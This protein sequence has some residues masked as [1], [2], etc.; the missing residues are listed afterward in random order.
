MSNKK[1]AVILSGCGVYDGAEINEVVLTL[2]AL[3]SNDIQYQCFAPDIEQYHTVDHTTGDTEAIPRNVL[4]ESARIVRGEILPLTDCLIE[5]FA[6]VIVPGGFGV[7]KS[8]SN[9]AAAESEFHVEK[10]TLSTLRKFADKKKPAGY[11]CIAPVLIPTV[12][13][14]DAK[15][16][17]G[18]D[19]SVIEFIRRSGGMHQLAGY[20]E[21]VF[22]EEKK[23]V[24]T[25]AFMLAKNL[26]EAKIGIDKLVDKVVSLC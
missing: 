18:N 24:T 6:A 4:K 10:S 22:D 17:I 20:D 5:E 2:L 26:R 25:P 12:Y 1:V 14:P 15:V 3:E 19:D 11:M 16:T 8:L 7:A 21:I 9:F 13:G 23:I